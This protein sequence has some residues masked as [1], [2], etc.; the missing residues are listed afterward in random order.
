MRSLKYNNIY[1]ALYLILFMAFG[2][3]LTMH[4]YRHY[5]RK[6]KQAYI[7]KAKQN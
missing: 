5:Y 2:E 1:G 4:Y 6:A 7:I 3:L